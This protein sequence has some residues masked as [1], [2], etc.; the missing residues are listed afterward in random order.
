M[1]RSYL[2]EE[3]C[4]FCQGN[5]SKNKDGD[6]E[7]MVSCEECGRSGALSYIKLHVINATLTFER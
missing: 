1:S 5:D 2:R 6:A 3:E 7:P 4:G